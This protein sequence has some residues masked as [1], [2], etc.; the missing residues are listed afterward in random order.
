MTT[1]DAV[2]LSGPGKCRRAGATREGLTG[3]RER[4]RCAGRVL[5]DE[6][7]E[8]VGIS[9]LQSF[10]DALVLEE[11]EGGHSANTVPLCDGLVLV[12]IDFEKHDVRVLLC[13]YGGRWKRRRAMLGRRQVS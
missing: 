5:L 10:D 7:S 13:E 2:G 11:K 9:A 3:A 4:R 1:C 8:S 6:S 12:Y